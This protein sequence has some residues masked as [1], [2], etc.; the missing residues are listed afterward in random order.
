MFYHK[1]S[2]FGELIRVIKIML[3]HEKVVF[4]E[5]NQPIF[6]FSL[7]D[8]DFK[9]FA[10]RRK[11]DLSI[12]CCRIIFI[13][14]MRLRVKYRYLNEKFVSYRPSPPPQKMFIF[15]FVKICIV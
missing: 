5:K 3:I 13:Y 2:A 15:Y 7:F 9:N 1:Y 12:K 14:R 11:L 6:V 10:F 4:D 8:I